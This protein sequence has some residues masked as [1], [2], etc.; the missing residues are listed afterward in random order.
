MTKEKTDK[1]K[2]SHNI[3]R[4]DRAMTDTNVRAAFAALKSNW[5]SLAEQEQGEQLRKLVDAGCS[6]RGL[7]RDLEQSAS[8]LGRRM[9]LA[10]TLEANRDWSAMLETLAPQEERTQNEL[11]PLEAARESQAEFQRNKTAMRAER[12]KGQ[13]NEAQPAAKAQTPITSRFT[14]VPAKQDP[15]VSER[16]IRREISA[17]DPSKKSLLDQI[18]LRV[19]EREEKIRRLV[20]IEIEPR[21]IR[22]AHPIPRQGRPLTPKK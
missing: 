12:Q 15:V 19:Q 4:H 2:R 16:S 9:K 1:T 20:S 7:A 3:T 13:M 22:N 5:P 21:P 8:T 10:E 14:L 6:V 18:K 11:G 17:E